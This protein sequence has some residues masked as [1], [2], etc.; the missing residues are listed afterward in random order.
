M[1]GVAGV[2][3][4][5][6]VVRR[7][8][9]SEVREPPLHGD[10]GDRQL[11]RAARDELLA[12]A[13]HADA[14]EHR[15]R[16]R[17][18]LALERLLEPTDAQPDVLGDVRRGDGRVRVRVHVL[19]RL[20]HA[21]GGP[22][23][24]GRLR[25]E[26]LV[27][28][29]VQHRERR[30]TGGLG[31]QERGG[32]GGAEHDAGGTGDL[33]VPPAEVLGAGA[34]GVVEHERAG[35]AAV[36]LGG[37]ALEEAP[38]EVHEVLPDVLDLEDER[39]AAREHHGRAGREGHVVAT[40]VHGA[41]AVG[42][43]HHDVLVAGGGLPGGLRVEVRRP[44][45]HRA[46]PDHAEPVREGA[47]RVRPVEVR[48]LVG[49]GEEVERRGE[50]GTGRLVAQSWV[51]AGLGAHQG[52]RV[53]PTGPGHGRLRRVRGTAAGVREPDG[54]PPP[55]GVHVRAVSVPSAPDDPLVAPV[56]P[57]VTQVVDD[58]LH[59]RE[60][61]PALRHGVRQVRGGRVDRHGDAVVHHRHDDVVRPDGEAHGA[62][63]P[64]T[65]RAVLDDVRRELDE[66]EFERHA[67]LDGQVRLAVPHRG[68]EGVH[69]R[70][71]LGR[72]GEVE[73]VLA[74]GDGHP[75]FVTAAS[76]S[77][78]VRRI[79]SM[80]DSLR[81]I[82][83]C[84]EGAAM[85]RSP[86]AWRAVF[87]QPT[88]APS[89]EE[90]MNSTPESSTT[91]RARPPPT[92]FAT[93]SRN[94]PALTMFSRPLHSS[95]AVSS[96]ASCTTMSMQVPPRSGTGARCNLP[97]RCPQAERPRRV[98]TSWTT[99]AAAMRVAITAPIAVAVPPSAPASG[100]PR[101]PSPKV[102]PPCSAAAVPGWAAP[103][104]CVRV[105]AAGSTK[106]HAPVTTASAHQ[107]A[108]GPVPATAKARTAALPTAP[109]TRPAVRSV[110]SEN[111]PTTLRNTSVVTIIID[112]FVANTSVYSCSENP[113]CCW[114]T[115]ELVAM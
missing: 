11:A 63:D 95:T 70:D 33:G 16:C 114:N 28:E 76:P 60:S 74:H 48:T 61:A 93:V 68:Q 107:T 67:V 51:R 79:L 99:T 71:V 115:N 41:A 50:V 15:V 53:T 14:A 9:A 18:D 104:A 25:R 12:H 106:P 100:V 49:V 103:T 78:Y 36:L 55:H 59:E 111:R 23:R 113:Y 66:G 56:D 35:L 13:V 94:A 64:A 58:H 37:D 87:R 42:R 26:L 21:A 43:P 62:R 7:R 40:H 5:A 90:S 102:N 109:T 92:T 4:E 2:L 112:A 27:R 98:A 73:H 75:Q 84:S 97:G 34:L 69:R 77:G 101:P 65:G 108:T 22:L 46:V 80:L 72:A 47:L 96:V 19:D 85:R 89:P 45:G 3:A 31:E 57:L 6:L 38:V 83:T 20:A 24:H 8:E 30:L 81:T 88:S 91:S 32:L 86:P 39:P 17:A 82:C 1:Q 105:I 52:E 44:Q 10:G 29:R 110:S 54:R